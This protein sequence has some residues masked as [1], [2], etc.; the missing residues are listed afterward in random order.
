M[1]KTYCK[2]C[3]WWFP[4]PEAEGV[5]TCQLKPPVVTVEHMNANPEGALPHF[6]IGAVTRFPSTVAESYCSKAEPKEE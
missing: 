6:L 2:D 1:S 3:N 4:S 5:G